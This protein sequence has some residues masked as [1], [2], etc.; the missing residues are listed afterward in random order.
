[1][2]NIWEGIAQERRLLAD[3]VEKLS[4]G[5][6]HTPSAL[7]GWRVR[8]VLAH[9]LW[10]LETPWPTI[11]L[12]WAATGFRV[13][14]LTEKRAFADARTP[15]QSAQALRNCA[16]ARFSA[17]PGIP[18]TTSMAE[19]LV[20]GL[21]V[22]LAVGVNAPI[23]AEHA[24]AALGFLV[25]NIGMYGFSLVKGLPRGLRFECPEASWTHGAGPLV[26]GPMDAMLLSLC[27]RTVALD[28]LGGDGADTFRA[29]FKR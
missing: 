6:W 22:K 24:N 20:H 28:Q 10:P 29:R 11:A 7:S 19:I 21:D 17:F 4:D 3:V 18:P 27:G 26:S 23:Q 1:M 25:G 2:D 16:T 5:Q 15:A 13:A 14:A 9:L 8:E 12:Q